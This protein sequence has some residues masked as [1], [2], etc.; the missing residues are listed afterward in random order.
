MT[1]QI[2]AIASCR[3]SSDEQLKN[4]LNRQRD[5]VITAANKLGVDFAEGGWWSGSVSSKKGAILVEKTFEKCLPYAIK[6]S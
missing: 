4:S 2:L 1:N 6:I 5:N 3:V